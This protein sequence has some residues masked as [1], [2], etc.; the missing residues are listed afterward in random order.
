MLRFATSLLLA[1]VVLDGVILMHGILMIILIAL[2]VLQMRDAHGALQTKHAL[3]HKMTHIKMLNFV[4]LK[5]AAMVVYV[6]HLSENMILFALREP[7][8]ALIIMIVDLALPMRVVHGV[9]QLINAWMQPMARMTMLDYVIQL[10]LVLVVYDGQI[11][12]Q[13]ILIVL[14][15][16]QD[17]QIFQIVT[18]VL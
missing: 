18:T 10:I 15:V 3:T 5:T 2:N 1:R 12:E 8:V 14:M 11:M 17:A 6:G 4:M 16:N 7:L 13:K 9:L